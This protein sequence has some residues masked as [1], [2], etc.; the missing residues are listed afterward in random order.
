MP[1]AS[2][3]TSSWG[4]AVDFSWHTDNPN[5][6]FASQACDIQA[7]VPNFLAFT[8]VR[9]HESASTDF[10]CVDQILEQLP[11][12]VIAELSR[13]AY[14]FS[15][16]SSNEG[17]DGQIRIFPILEYDGVVNCMRFDEGIVT[18]VDQLSAEALDILR[19]YLRGTQ[20]TQIVLQPGDFFIFKNPQILHRR[21]AFE[22]LPEGKARWL[23]RT[24]GR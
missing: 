14:L 19:R 3:T 21:K 8:A 9:N 5:W 2:G 4:A 20:G 1:E 23:R 10:V 12:W 24:Y 13:P 16:P 18:A 6:P 15:A 22:P 11:C 7:C 17:F